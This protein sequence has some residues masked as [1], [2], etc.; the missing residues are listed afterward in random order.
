VAVLA[1][2][3]GDDYGTY[4]EED[5]KRGEEDNRGADKVSGIGEEAA[6]SYLL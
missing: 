2:G 3:F 1:E 4:D 5:T 6:Q